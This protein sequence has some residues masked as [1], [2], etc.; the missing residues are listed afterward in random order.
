MNANLESLTR[1]DTSYALED[2][3]SQDQFRHCQY[4]HFFYDNNDFL[5]VNFGANYRSVAS[6]PSFPGTTIY[7]LIIQE[8]N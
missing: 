5:N 1:L 8:E 4:R 6:M 7:F 2:T 3:L